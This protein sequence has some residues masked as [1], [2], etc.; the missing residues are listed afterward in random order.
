MHR[1]CRRLA[2]DEALTMQRY[3][4]SQGQAPMSN[5]WNRPSLSLKFSLE[6]SNR[7]AL[8]RWQIGIF[9]QLPAS[10]WGAQLRWGLLQLPVNPD[11]ESFLLEKG[12]HTS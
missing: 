3:D 4:S 12:L 1:Y 7:P 5:G 8:L 10:S 9:P 2:Q 6:L 11:F